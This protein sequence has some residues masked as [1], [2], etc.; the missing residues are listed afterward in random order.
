MEYFYNQKNLN[1]HAG[2]V[3]RFQALYESG[4]P[5]ENEREE[6]ETILNRISHHPVPPE[7]QSILLITTDEG[8]TEV[9]GGLIADWYENSHSIHLTYLIIAEA[10]RNKG[11]AKQF[12]DEGI[13]WIKDWILH[14]KG[15]EIRNV[16]FESNIPW[17]TKKG[18]DNFDAVERLKI[19]SKYGAR[20]I[21]I[22]YTQPALDPEKEEVD[23]LFLLSFSQYNT[24]GN[25]IPADEITEFLKDLYHGLGVANLERNKAFIRMQE[26]LETLKDNHGEVELSV[27]PYED[28]IVFNE[29]VPAFR[30][31]K[32][33]VTL[34]FMEQMPP[35]RTEMGSCNYFSS[36]ERDLLNFQNQRN[37]PLKSISLVSKLDARLIFP[38]TYKYS[39]EG[40]THKMLSHRSEVEVIVSLSYTH[41][42]LSNKKIWHLTIKP[43]GESPFFTEYDLVKLVSLFGSTQEDSTVKNRIKFRLE[44]DPSKA[45]SETDLIKHILKK[46]MLLEGLGTGIVQLD[47]D[48]LA[49]LDSDTADTF[50]QLFQK[51]ERPVLEE[52]KIKTLGRVIC[53]IILGIFDFNRMDDEEIYDTIQALMPSDSSFLVLCRG[54]LLKISKVDEIIEAV[55]DTIIVSPYLLIPSAVLSHN[56]YILARAKTLLDDTLNNSTALIINDLDMVQ[57]EINKSVNHHY[58]TDIFQYPSEQ[59]IVEYGNRQRGIVNLYNHITHRLDELFK[60]IEMKQESRSN[61]S[62]AFLN[63]FLGLIAMVQLTGIFTGLIQFKHNELVFYLIEVILAVLIFFLVRIKKQK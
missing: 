32:A 18:N 16:F 27:I 24:R 15:I 23:N 22:A 49:F 50:F 52:G 42:P 37:Q 10:H 63:A 7:P 46:E 28:S 12:I 43:A 26:E 30:F 59:T 54:T 17:K 44:R 34:H 40:L 20:W 2:L 56:E 5:D 36:F 53:G 33:S 8:G 58:L 60:V 45:L 13:Q 6:F 31:D 39:S 61:L 62:D 29:E 9:T 41:F 1:K 21:D 38:P 14:N 19:F 47:I 4:F 11:L 55:S 57:A 48:E 3:K 25:K 51:R 35:S